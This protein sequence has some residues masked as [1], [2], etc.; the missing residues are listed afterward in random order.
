[1]ERTFAAGP[2]ALLVYE[3]T[4]Q[5]NAV[6]HYGDAWVSLRL[7]V[8]IRRTPRSTASAKTPLFNATAAGLKIVSRKR[9]TN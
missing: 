6:P 2:S 4:Q 8:V 7:I 3:T 1:M 9:N 5:L